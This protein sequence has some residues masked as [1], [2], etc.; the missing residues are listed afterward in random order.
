MARFYILIPNDSGFDPRLTAAICTLPQ[1]MTIAVAL[2]ALRQKQASPVP[3]HTLQ[4][5]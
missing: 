5:A 4:V 2:I 3:T 1:A